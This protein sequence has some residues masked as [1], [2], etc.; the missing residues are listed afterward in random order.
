M[1]ITVS[2]EE[3]C[4]TLPSLQIVGNPPLNARSSPK[5]Q[6]RLSNWT[7]FAHVSGSLCSCG[8]SV[9]SWLHTASWMSSAGLKMAPVAILCLVQ[10]S[11]THMLMHAHIR[12]YNQ[13]VQVPDSSGGIFP[14]SIKVRETITSC[15]FFFLW[16]T[17]HS[18]A[19]RIMCSVFPH[20]SSIADGEIWKSWRSL[21]FN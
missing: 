1:G 21:F 2:R 14:H 8:L 16:E 12:I 10:Y 13:N 15:S 19:P 9:I 6:D 20:G 7:V 18:F 5:E 4:R 3:N 11:K 17:W